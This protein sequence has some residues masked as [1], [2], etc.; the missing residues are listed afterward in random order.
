MQG[1]W[2]WLLLAAELGLVILAAAAIAQSSSAARFCQ[3]CDEW[4][5]T[6]TV[7]KTHPNVGEELVSRA[8]AGDWQ[9]MLN[10]VSDQ[11]TNEKNYCHIV[12][13]ACP[14][15]SDGTVAINRAVNGTPKI[16]LQSAVSSQ[17]A[18][19]LAAGAT[20]AKA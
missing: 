11:K 9:G 19:T 10:V 6:K 1:T 14:K 18:T 12:L 4:W 7:H 20:P 5:K 2:Y 8:R 13:S 17:D 15:C 3:G 16:L